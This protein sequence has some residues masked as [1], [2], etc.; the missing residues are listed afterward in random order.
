VLLL[1]AG[2]KLKLLPE[3]R[4]ELLSEFDCKAGRV[5]K[6]G[7]ELVCPIRWGLANGAIGRHD[8]SLR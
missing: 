3:S 6:L 2:K 1:K 8:S 7:K 5:K 4:E